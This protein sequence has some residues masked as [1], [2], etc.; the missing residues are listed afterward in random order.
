MG[1]QLIT[2]DDLTGKPIEDEEAEHITLSVNGDNYELDLGQP[3]AKK[4]WDALNPFIEKASKIEARPEPRVRRQGDGT[5]K[6][7]D[8]E[9]LAAMRTW[10]REQGH[11]VADKGRVAQNLQDLYHEAHKQ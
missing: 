2:V 8:P 7:T 11:E 1:K 9:L 4:F 3:S 6:K 10:L 5:K